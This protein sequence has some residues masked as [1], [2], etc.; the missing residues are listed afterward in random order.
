MKAFAAAP[1]HEGELWRHLDTA[2]GAVTEL[3]AQID[4]LAARLDPV[5]SPVESDAGGMLG[6]PRKVAS[7]LSTRVMN[8]GDVLG[9]AIAKVRALVE[10]LEI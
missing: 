4:R 7:P 3:H 6:D 10:R 2:E 9:A 5:L 1:A 8:H